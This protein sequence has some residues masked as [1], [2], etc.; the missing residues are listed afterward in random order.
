MKLALTTILYMT[1]AG[2]TAI[3]PTIDT[4]QGSNRTPIY[5]K[6]TVLRF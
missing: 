3:Q 1:L 2:C 5:V 6:G 4:V